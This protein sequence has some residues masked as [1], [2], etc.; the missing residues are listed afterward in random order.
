MFEHK[1]LQFHGSLSCALSL[2]V[3]SHFQLQNW[4][5]IY[6]VLLQVWSFQHAE[7]GIIQQI[8]VHVRMQEDY[9]KY[10]SLCKQSQGLSD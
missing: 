5:A 7:T 10:S 3:Q 1:M 9:R 2:V 6:P 8:A 4:S